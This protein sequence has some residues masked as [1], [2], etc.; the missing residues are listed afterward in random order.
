MHI[1]HRFFAAILI[2]MSGAS[3]MAAMTGPHSIDAGG[4]VAAACGAFIAGTVGA[5]LFGQADRQGIVMACLGA[6]LTTVMGAAIGGLGY[7]TVTAEPI[8]IFIAPMIV[9][10]MIL[11]SAHVLLVWLTTMAGA[12]LVM[13]FLRSRPDWD[14]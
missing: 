1:T 11:S 7:G 13:W 2:A 6:V 8:A 14:D 3:V 5:P 9:G 10:A 4:V 12:H